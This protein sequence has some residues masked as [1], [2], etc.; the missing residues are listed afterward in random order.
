MSSQ[1]QP[2]GQPQGA[3]QQQQ[4]QQVVNGAAGGGTAQRRVCS[5]KPSK[6]TED[7]GFD[8]YHAQIEGY[9]TQYECWD[10]IDGNA[11]ADPNEP[12][13]LRR[14]QFARYVLLLGMCPKDSKKVCKMATAR[15]MWRSFE[16]NKT[17]RAYASEIR[18]RSK[19]YSTK[20]TTV[21]DMEKYLEKLEDMRRQ[22][23]NMNAAITDEEM[24]R[25]ILQSVVDSHRNVVRLFSRGA[26]PDLATVVN[27]LLGEAETD[28]ACAMRVT[29]VSEDT[30]ATKV[31]SQ[32]PIKHN[33]KNKF[34]KY[35]GKGKKIR[36]ESRKCF[37]CKK[38]GHL[39]ADC[40]GWKALKRMRA[41]ILANIPSRRI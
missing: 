35:N 7:G 27:T 11:A 28:R 33:P 12:E 30:Q 22:L 40:Y 26:P 5:S 18:L 19:M 3:G 25:I 38:K 9:L 13:W 14:N 34:K 8:L 37:F 29:D 6:Y 4:Q 15:E 16:Q 10:V 36:Q 17:K 31:M 21:E 24:A 20:F 32:C 23:A 2:Q 41:R 1:G 39:R